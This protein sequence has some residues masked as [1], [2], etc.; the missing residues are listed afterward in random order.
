MDGGP[1]SGSVQAES[2]A[3]RRDGVIEVRELPRR[4]LDDCG[5][6]L[7][8]ARCESFRYSHQFATGRRRPVRIVGGGCLPR[9]IASGQEPQ[10]GAQITRH[11]TGLTLRTEEDHRL[12]DEWAV[13]TDQPERRVST[14]AILAEHAE[15]VAAQLRVASPG[16]EPFGSFLRRQEGWEGFEVHPI[17]A[18]VLERKHQRSGQRLG[19]LSITGNHS[20]R[21][22]TTSV[23]GWLR[24]NRPRTG[25]A[26]RTSSISRD[27]T[28]NLPAG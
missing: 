25:R 2:A 22:A 3:K 14:R 10:E 1:P 20:D 28:T 27:T 13:L 9:T 5:S 6:R 4:P 17:S 19:K 15:I 8:P 23:T 11:D 16:P 24:M 18:V 7:L 21:L 26:S 12:I